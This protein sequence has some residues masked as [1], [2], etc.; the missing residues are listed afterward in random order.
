MKDTVKKL[1]AIREE[2]ERRQRTRDRLEGQKDALLKSLKDDFGLSSVEEAEAEADR[3]E[4]KLADLEA[5]IKVRV[6]K[7]E[8]ELTDADAA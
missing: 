3:M 6:G 2:L 8:K 4:G 1:E 7:L 5:D